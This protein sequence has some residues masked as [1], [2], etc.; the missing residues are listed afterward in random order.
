[1]EINLAQKHQ[2]DPNCGF[3]LTQYPDGQKM[4]SIHHDTIQPGEIITIKSRFAWSD[5]E[6]ITQA[7]RYFQQKYPFNAIH[8][9]LPYFLGAR[10]DRTFDD[11]QVHYLRDVT[12]AAINTLGVQQVQVLDPHSD[13]LE[14]VVH[15]LKKLSPYFI[16]DK[17][18]TSM[19][20]VDYPSS[21]DFLY[22]SPDG[23]ARKKIMKTKISLL[24]NKNEILFC[25]KVR[26]EKTGDLTD[27][28]IP[29]Q[30]LGGKDCWIIDDIC[31]R[32][33]TFMN[34]AGELKKANAGNIFLVVSHYEG[35][36]TT[37]RLAEAGIEQVFTTNSIC[38]VSSPFVT[39]YNV[40]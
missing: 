19:Y 3:E 36:A 26:N 20:Q 12:G 10:A 25:D 11:D 27:V 29:S 37:S 7:V 32:G 28:F 34:L 14:G 39:Q 30:D 24:D 5:L 9:Y 38:E 40:F 18:I 6:V 1:M 21:A 13:V 8:L 35:T 16:A 22:V 31:S 15:N 2:K 23:G 17:A 4:L 33:G